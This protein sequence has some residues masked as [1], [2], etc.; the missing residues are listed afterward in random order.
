METSSYATDKSDDKSDDKSSIMSKWFHKIFGSIEDEFIS[1]DPKAGLKLN[2]EDA[3]LC[4]A[5][6]KNRTDD[7]TIRRTKSRN[8]HTMPRHAQKSI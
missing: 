8:Y 5:R 1:V 3:D 7:L 6:L 4:L 2:G